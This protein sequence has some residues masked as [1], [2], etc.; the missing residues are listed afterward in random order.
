MANKP[1]VLI[2]RDGWGRNPRGPEVAQETG[3]ATVLARTPFTDHLL[4]TCPHALLGASGQDVGLPDGQM[5]N[6]E[7]GHLNLGAGRVVFQDLCRI[8]NAIADG[9]L[10]DNPVI[11]EAFAKA[12]DSRLHLLGLLSDGGVHSHID[13]TIGIVKIAAQMGVKDIMIHAITDGRDT[14]PKSGAA[15]L[16]QLQKATEPCGA[17]VAT[18][19]GR[20]YAMDRDKRWDRVKIGWDAIVLGRGEQCTGSPAD[21]ARKCYE[22]GT[23]DEFLK[24]A[25][26]CEG[27]EPRIHDGDV[28]FFTN[29]RADR[30]RELSRAFLYEDFNGFEREVQPK[31]HYITMSEYEACYPSPI[32]FEQ[33]KLDNISARSSLAPVCASCA[34]PKPRNM[35]TSPFSSTVV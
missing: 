21:Y 13:H 17:R 3:D 9:S 33:E 16:E 27:D 34:L 6:S 29:F 30:A 15:F 11:K 18:V 7:V 2:I 1:V 32:V 23:T 22:E 20:F 5:G 31:V 28:V 10:A 14:D 8:S 12:K 25:I 4:A 19:I 35:P 24:P 26:F